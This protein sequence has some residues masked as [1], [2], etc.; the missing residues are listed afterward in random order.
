MCVKPGECKLVLTSL[1]SVWDWMVVDLSPAPH[2]GEN[3]ADGFRLI[4]LLPLPSNSN[5][6][7]SR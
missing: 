6:M 2:G 1:S 5:Q 3:G 4:Q 7:L